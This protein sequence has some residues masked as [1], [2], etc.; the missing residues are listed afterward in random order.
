[1]KV[2]A[3]RAERRVVGI[4]H[5][6]STEV[7]HRYLLAVDNWYGHPCV[8]E[9]RLRFRLRGLE[10]RGLGCGQ[11]NSVQSATGSKLFLLGAS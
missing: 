11:Y 8:K 10:S 2:A 6:R 9:R 5:Q 3:R 7:I 1:M 4:S